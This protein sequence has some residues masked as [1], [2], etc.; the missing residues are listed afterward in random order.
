MQEAKLYTRLPGSQTGCNICLWR[1]R[2][3]PG[4]TGACHMYKNLD[5]SL[6]N[7][8]YG[9]PSSMAV[10]PVEKK[11]LYHFYPGT[12]VFSLGSWG[13]NF[14]CSDCQNWQISTAGQPPIGSGPGELMPQDAVNLAVKHGCSGIA[15]TYNEPTVWYEYTLDSAQLARQNNLYTVYVTNGYMTR[16]ALDGIGPFLDAWRVDVKAFS[17][18]VY[19]KWCGI[20]N[21]QEIL[22]TAERAMHH[23]GMHV[24]V[25]TN[26]VPTVN[27]DD[28]QLK[29]MASWI[30]DNLGPLV[31]WH[32]TRFQ[33]YAK[34]ASVGATPFDTLQRAVTI[35]HEA[36][37]KFVYA[38]NVP[39]N[40]YENTICYACS[41]Q[42]VHRLGYR[43]DSFGLDGSKCGYCGAELN[44]RVTPGGGG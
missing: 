13:C 10:D 40:E 28:I 16:E 27:D 12:R 39:G 15:W 20:Q 8:N 34:M 42:V 1:C 33:P 4:K 21:W 5:G 31:P 19:Q 32:V 23:L 2:I 35:G 17:G 9:L 44:F 24:E 38:G 22:R 11:P 7:L 37:L 43:V 41:R 30:N 26:I 3:N 36:G 14:K 25:V 18:D 29:G 6:F